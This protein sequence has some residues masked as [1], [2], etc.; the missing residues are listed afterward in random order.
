MVLL[1]DG[2]DSGWRLTVHALI[3]TWRGERMSRMARWR[4][5]R[6]LRV[7]TGRGARV[8]PLLLIWRHTQSPQVTSTSP[9]VPS[10]SRSLPIRR[11]HAS[12][13]AGCHLRL[14]R[15]SCLYSLPVAVTLQVY[16]CPPVAGSHHA[17]AHG[18]ARACPGRRRRPLLGR[19]ET[20]SVE[21]WTM[22]RGPHDFPC[23]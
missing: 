18:T 15:S 13:V 23:G 11:R 21:R 1:G 22:K 4:V 8:A 16:S 5:V 20:S 12:P 7:I 17:H 2:H 19:C 6:S 3:S 9:V 10:P 14:G